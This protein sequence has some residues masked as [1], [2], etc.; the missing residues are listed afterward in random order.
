VLGQS[1][2]LLLA[3]SSGCHHRSLLTDPEILRQTA[4]SG[5]EK[6]TLVLQAGNWEQPQPVE[7]GTP[8]GDLYIAEALFRAEDYA[9]SGKAFEE[10]ADKHKDVLEVHERAL[11]MKAESEYQLG[12]FAEAR[13]SFQEF[14]KAY[15][16]SRHVSSAMQHLFAISDTWLE[17]ARKDVRHGKPS[18]VH[19]FLNFDPDR[20]PYFDIDGHAI[21]TLKYVRENDPNGPLADDSLMM[22]AGYHFTMGDYTEAADLT[23]HLIHNYPHSEFQAQAHLM[24]AEAKI[25]SYKGHS[26]DGRKLEEARRTLRSAVAQFPEQLDSDRQRVF[27]ELEEIRHEQ[28]K[29]QFEIAEWYHQMG[30][31]SPKMSD[32]Y[33]RSARLYYQYV[34]KNF[35]GTKWADRAAEQLGKI[36]DVPPPRPK[37]ELISP[38]QSSEPKRSWLS[39][40][41]ETVAERIR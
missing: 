29:T 15:P 39:S 11:F 38:D 22:A 34:Q 36:P 21:E 13:D 17:D 2:V 18:T 23:D 5:T 6:E 41:Y 33:Y 37:K 19:R 30:N 32:T 25:H 14:R 3:V 7:P 40:A 24:N 12:H 4:A 27:R 26:Y 16:G 9:K 8:H 28:A 10:V 35:P 20:K 1:C 31:R